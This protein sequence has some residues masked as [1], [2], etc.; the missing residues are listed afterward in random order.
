MADTTNTVPEVR[1]RARANA[2][3][4][5]AILSLL[6]AIL[7]LA[8]TIGARN[9]AT[10]AQQS[11]DEANKDITELRNEIDNE[12]TGTPMPLEGEGNNVPGAKP[13]DFE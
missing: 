4:A 8:L 13:G 11:A 5:V 9:Q 3:I 1:A 7:C 12:L 2:A 6:F 10:N